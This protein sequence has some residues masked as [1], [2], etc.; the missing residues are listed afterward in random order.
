MAAYNKF[1]CFVEDLAE[2]YHNLGADALTVALFASV[3]APLAAD[4]TLANIGTEI[5]YTN[6]VTTPNA[7]RVIGTPTT[8]AQTAGVYS[9]ILPDMT[10]TATGGAIATFRWIVIYNA[11]AS[12]GHQLVAWFDYGAGSITL[13]Q[14][15]TLTIDFN[16]SGGTTAF[17]TLG[18]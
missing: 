17:L 7:S 9:L 8:S 18:A 6:V 12:A 2:K 11:T 1:D 15:E 16:G 10:I 5:S 3:D 4:T 14:N 13:A